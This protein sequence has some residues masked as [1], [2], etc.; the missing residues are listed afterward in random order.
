MSIDDIIIGCKEGNRKC[1][2]AL[3]QKF[4]PV[5]MA[6]CIRYIGEQEMAKDALQETFINA[7]K[8]IH[9]FNFQGS[10]EGWL[11]RVAVTSSLSVKKKYCSICF[12]NMDD[13][14]YITQTTIPDA[15]GDMNIED[16]CSICMSWMDFHIR[17]SVNNLVS[18]KVHRGLH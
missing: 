2:D 7:F 14:G 4:A 17:R 3:V 16:L 1:Q 11:R 6:I 9:T 13:I 10:F 15:H 8:Y 12:E 18:Q 5:L